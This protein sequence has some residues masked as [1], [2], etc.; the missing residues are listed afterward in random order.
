MHRL[1]QSPAWPRAQRWFSRSQFQVEHFDK[2][3]ERHRKIRVASGNVKAE[4]FG[5]E[6]HADEKEKTEGEH[7]DRWMTFDEAAYRAS[8]D[9]HDDHCQYHSDDH[10]GDLIDHPDSGDHGIKRKHNVEESNLHEHSEQ[11]R[12]SA[13]VSMFVL[14]FNVVVNFVRAFHQKK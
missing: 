7:L 1:V 13:H 6:V 5:D 10:D 2:E 8:E 9:H 4:T 11:R 14:S 12:N 3:R